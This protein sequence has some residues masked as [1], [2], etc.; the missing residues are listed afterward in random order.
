MQ[1]SRLTD[2]PHAAA[3]TFRLASLVA[4][5]CS[6][7]VQD[8]DAQQA[9]LVAVSLSAPSGS[10]R[11]GNSLLLGATVRN[12]G[13]QTSG[14]Y[15]VSLY[16]SPNPSI[17]TQDILLD[18]FSRDSVSV[19]AEDVFLAFPT[20]PQSMPSDTYYIGMIISY[21]GDP[22]SGDNTAY[23]P[24]PILISVHAD[25]VVVSV[26]APP[27]EYHRGDTLLLG[28]TV[29]NDGPMGCLGYTATFYASRDTWITAG[30]LQLTSFARPALASSNSDAFLA[31][32]VLPADM[33]RGSYYIG[34]IVTYA[35]DPAT[36]NNWG[37]DPDSLA[38]AVPADLSVGGIDV[39]SKPLLPGMGTAVANTVSNNGPEVCEGYLITFYASTN[40]LITASDYA[41]GS[42]SRGEILVGAVQER[43][44]PVALPPGIPLGTYYVGAI[45][46]YE[47]DP[48][49]ADNT[50]YDPEPI[51]VAE[52]ADLSVEVVDS[53][54]YDVHTG[55]SFYVFSSIL[56]RGPETCSG[57]TIRYY[58]SADTNITS[59]D[60][61]IKD[62]HAGSLEPGQEHNYS[63]FCNLPGDIEESPYYVGVIVTYGDDPVADNNTGYD[64]DPVSVWEYADLELRWVAGPMGVYAPGDTVSIA[65]ATRNNG[66]GH[67]RPSGYIAHF[68]A[69]TDSL[70]SG[71]SDPRLD[72]CTRAF[73]S[74]GETL[75]WRRDVRLPGLPPG[76]YYLGMEIQS[77]DD[78]DWDNNLG[79]S[80]FAISV[81]QVGELGVE[82]VVAPEGEYHPGDLLLLGA[83][84]KNNGPLPVPG[85]TATVYA[86]WDT[87]ITTRDR[88]LI[89][90]SRG[91]VAPGA[92][93]TFLAAPNLPAT[94]P[95]GTHYI[96]LIVDYEYDQNPDNDAGHDPVPIVVTPVPEYVGFSGIERI[97]PTQVRV[98]WPS[99]SGKAYRVL[100][101]THPNTGFDEVVEE[102][103]PAT[104]PTNTF[105]IT[106]QFAAEYYRVATE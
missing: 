11:P 24:E 80:L 79:C 19:G 22:D 38:V 83:T 51:L 47:D 14:S 15:T 58:A 57:Y 53:S 21:A 64:P 39:P 105:T 50:A 54:S 89:S 87:E 56:N 101:A 84:V 85:Y 93:D 30:D 23:D 8:A 7:F 25:L 61:R 59:S 76:F 41:M 77:V 44:T 92:L 96:G 52:G 28:A 12:D 97:S 69:S 6:A 46:T 104:P 43:S 98:H 102:D 18:S 81:V 35:D 67:G 91:A 62:E 74:P 90:F 82:T 94:M 20:L 100:R 73:P 65:N 4:L 66:P 55:S 10:Y 49:T 9:D 5:M 103:I 63:Y 1:G 86:S 27:G 48:N 17:T 40:P 70:I 88:E 42:V 3:G 29:R 106:T 99:M 72:S 16:A 32:P 2:F 45:V 13:P 36:A 26:N 37:Y 95:P 71:H 78:P 75:E 34:L 33:A 60:I 68:Y 31:A